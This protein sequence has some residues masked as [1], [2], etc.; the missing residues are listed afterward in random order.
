M[1]NWEIISWRVRG[2]DESATLSMA[3]RVRS[4]KKEGKKIF[5]LTLGEQSEGPPPIVHE[6][7]KQYSEDDTIH[8]Y[9]P[10]DGI[11]QLKNAISVKLEKENGVSVSPDEIF[12]GNGAKQCIANVLIATLEPHDK[13]ILISPYWVTYYDILRFLGVQPVV[14]PRNE[15][16]R[17]YDLPEVRD[18][19]ILICNFP[20]NPTGDIIEKEEVYAILR[21]LEINPRLIV[22]SDE[23]YEYFVF[24]GEHLSLLSLGGEF[25][26]RI[27]YVNGVSKSFGMTGWRVGYMVSSQVIK[28]S[29]QKVQGQFTSGVCAIAQKVAAHLI[30]K[31]KE[32]VKDRI[33]L[34]RMKRDVA[35]KILSE[36][37]YMRFDVPRGAFYIFASIEELLNKMDPKLQIKNEEDFVMYMLDNGIAVVGGRAFGSP[38]HIRISLAPPLPELEEALH[39]FAK[40]ITNITR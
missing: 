37:P 30:E 10:V 32:I 9:P 33:E 36:V 22:I 24:E 14:I 18:A 15:L 31:G 28:E 7:I 11:P 39:L 3:R 12:V 23:I 13:A 5:N 27:V 16:V 40:V 8:F 25:R 19:K 20:C 34:Y 17:I 26:E 29:V 6:L 4:L 21:C 2:I 35:C 1:T 38:N